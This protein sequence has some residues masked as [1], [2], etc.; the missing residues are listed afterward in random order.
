M[1]AVLMISAV[2]LSPSGNIWNSAYKNPYTLLHKNN[3]YDF[4][5]L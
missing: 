4:Y 5:S 1:S 2:F 3:N